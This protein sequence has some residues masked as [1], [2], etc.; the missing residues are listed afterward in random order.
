MFI[1]FVVEAPASS[2]AMAG[3]DYLHQSMLEDLRASGLE[4]IAR[5]SGLI[6]PNNNSIPAMV[7]YAMPVP[8]L[9]QH[10]VVEE[11]LED[12]GNA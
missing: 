12:T 7:N 6:G 9:Q 10:L 11:V 4:G 8:N 3:A 5:D 1:V 2:N